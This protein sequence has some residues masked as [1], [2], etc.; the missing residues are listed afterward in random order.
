MRS[1]SMLILLALL[2]AFS[3]GTVLSEDA[4]NATNVTTDQN[5]TN[6]TTVTT[7]VTEPVSK[8]KQLSN[9]TEG[10]ALVLGK[11]IAQEYSDVTRTA[12]KNS[13]FSRE[14]GTTTPAVKV[15][16]TNVN[17]IGEKFVE[18]TNQAVGSWDLTGWM[19]AS[20]G[21]ATYTFPEFILDDRLSVRVH[22][23][24]GA[25]TKTDLYTNSTT[26][27]WIDD[28]VSLHNAEGNTISRYDLLSSPDKTIGSNDLDRLIQY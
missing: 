22:E 16:I 21:N 24:N 28:E 3:A 13:V 11:N 12:D 5:I 2:M 25:G 7:T 18:V 20:A 9:Y 8:Y 23:G 19:L 26:P 14:A 17:T 6:T 27:L 15:R 1:A 4:L 10:A